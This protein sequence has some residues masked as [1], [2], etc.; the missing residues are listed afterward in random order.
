MKVIIV[1]LNCEKHNVNL[2]EEQIKFAH[3]LVNNGILYDIKVIDEM[4]WEDIK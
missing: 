4:E 3:Y 2:S 1:D